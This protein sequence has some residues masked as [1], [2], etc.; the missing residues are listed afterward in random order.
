VLLAQPRSGGRARP[1]ARAGADLARR[2]RRAGGGGARLA[3]RAARRARADGRPAAPELLAREAA[4]PSSAGARALRAHGTVPV[5]GGAIS[6]GGNL[7]DWLERTLADTDTSGLADEPPDGHGLTFLTLL[8]GERS[9]GWN[10]GAR[11]AVSGLSF[12]TTA[13]E[14]VQVAL[15]R[16]AYRFAEI[17]D[18][19][20]EVREIVA[21]GAALLKNADWMQ[22]VADVLGRPLTASAVEEG[23]ARG[24]AVAALER[25]GADPAEAPLG[26]VFEP[27]PERTEA[28]LAARE[29][30]R[31]LYRVL[32]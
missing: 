32:A 23:S 19:M 21:T 30:Q 3:A 15:E 1:G 16:V 18:L 29:R 2:P 6:D 11:G 4:S 14:L 5:H 20:P 8:G 10:A 28:Y 22:I 13:R 24:A 26:R 25:L 12:S 7:H 17:A 27:R 31:R 9:P